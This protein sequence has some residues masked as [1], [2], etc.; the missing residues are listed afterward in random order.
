MMLLLV[1]ILKALT[2]VALCA[3][4]GQG[5]LYLFAGAKRETNFV[6]TTF[7]MLTSPV[8]KITRLIAPRFIVDQHIGF[9]AFFLLL[10]LWVALTIT[11]VK[12]VIT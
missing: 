5:I 1:M 11:K 2:E 4:L 7:K 12:L 9:L 6:Y 8:T 10:V 3:F